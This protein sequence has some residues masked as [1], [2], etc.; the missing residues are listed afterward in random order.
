MLERDR[1]GDSSRRVDVS[2]EEAAVLN[3][4]KA[5]HLPSSQRPEGSRRSWVYMPGH[6]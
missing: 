6:L 1:E 3:A 4:G 5:C 2:R